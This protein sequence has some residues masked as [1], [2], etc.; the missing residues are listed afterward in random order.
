LQNKEKRKLKYFLKAALLD[1]DGYIK[2]LKN[3]LS[4]HL[5]MI[6][7]ILLEVAGNIG[8]AGNLR[9]ACG[10]L[11]FFSSATV[12]RRLKLFFLI[13]FTLQRPLGAMPRPSAAK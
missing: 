6:K 3:Y 2:G 13:E 4:N 11:Y 8:G 12:L 1:S 9:V 10:R 7:I 5:Y